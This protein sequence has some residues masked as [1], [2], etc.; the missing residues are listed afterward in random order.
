MKRVAWTVALLFV[1]SAAYAQQEHHMAMHEMASAARLQLADNGAGL[2]TVRVG[3]LNLAANAD[4]MQVAQP[5]DQTLE[6]PFDGW[7]TAYHPRMTD[8]LGQTLPGRMLHHVAFWNTERSDF[9]CPNKEEHIFGAGGEMNDWPAQPGIGYRVHKGERIRVSS[10]FHNPTATSYADA[11]LEVRIEYRRAGEGQPLM[12]VYP[13]WFDVMQ[14]GNSGY[15]LAAGHNHRSGKFRLNYSGRLLGVGGHLHDYGR[16]LTLK[17]LSR[18]ETIAALTPETN[19]A[20]QIVKMPVVLFTDRGG[21]ALPKGEEIEVDADYDNLT[22]KP[23]PEGAM[24][25]VVG[26]F[27]PADDHEMAALR[28]NTTSAAEHSH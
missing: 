5:G 17:D 23:L 6:I 18:G 25:I 11:Y 24:G 16:G 22:G 20:G 15:D 12:S 4:H 26:Y 21:Y 8:A 7:L 27:V 28:R 3:P 9:L 1:V 14:C 19:S 13:T 10:M 2:L